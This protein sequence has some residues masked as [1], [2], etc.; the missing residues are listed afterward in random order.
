V[1]TIIAQYSSPADT[2][3]E[4]G[5]RE[6]I[7]YSFPFKVII[8]RHWTEWKIVVDNFNKN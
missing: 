8:C 5:P 4:S 2:L 6:L 1:T 7:F 3:K